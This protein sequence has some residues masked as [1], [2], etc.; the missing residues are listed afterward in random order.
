M[1]WAHE[2][3]ATS[4]TRT[5]V[6]GK[7]QHSED[8]LQGRLTHAKP[9]T[10]AE[11][12]PGEK[13]RWKR[14]GNP[15]HRG[16]RDS[17][18]RRIRGTDDHPNRRVGGQSEEGDAGSFVGVEP[19]IDSREIFDPATEPRIHATDFKGVIVDKRSGDDPA[20]EFVWRE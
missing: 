6:C 14:G 15:T 18:G 3:T 9:A 2:R 20:A 19:A 8:P 16:Q 12:H 1:P 10:C 4:R 17:R 13:Y 5:A 7:Q 11:H